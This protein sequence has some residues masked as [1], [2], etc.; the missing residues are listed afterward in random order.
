MEDEDTM[1]YIEDV[2]VDIDNN[3]Y[4]FRHGVDYAW[5]K[6]LQASKMLKESMGMFFRNLDLALMQE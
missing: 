5:A 6:I 4:P 2:P 3:C 1:A